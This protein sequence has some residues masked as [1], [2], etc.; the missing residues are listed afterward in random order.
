[1]S[2]NKL[3]FL[4]FLLLIPLD[5]HGQQIPEDYTDEP[6]FIDMLELGRNILITYNMGYDEVRG[7]PYLFE[8]FHN[9]SLYFTNRTKISGLKINYDCINRD[10]LF[11]WEGKNYSIG[12]NDIE[13]FT[14]S[15]DQT[16]SILLFKRIFLPQAR[17][18][19]YLEILY[20][21]R[22]YL[23]KR[24]LKDFQEA[25]VKSPYQVSRDYNEYINKV[26]YFV[27]LD[28]NDIQILK[29]KKKAVLKVFPDN[30]DS[31]EQFMKEEHINL[32]DETDLV[33]LIKFYDDM[34][35]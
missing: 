7:T 27:K 30:T 19:E 9:G 13:Y 34:K 12:R 2:K 20:D 31:I 29:P 8:E 23:F 22:S 5:Q 16:D 4:L 32:K 1:M 25:E 3:I 6:K 35:E 21:A 11:E 10:I 18:Q 28:G 24:Y 26:E 17:E 14:I 33:R 15:T